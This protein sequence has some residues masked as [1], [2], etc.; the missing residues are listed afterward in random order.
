MVPNLSDGPDMIDELRCLW[1]IYDVEGRCSR[2]A[3]AP[4]RPSF[5]SYFWS[6]ASGLPDLGGRAHMWGGWWMCGISD[7]WARVTSSIREGLHFLLQHA[8]WCVDGAPG[9]I[10]DTGDATL[11]LTSWPFHK[12]NPKKTTSRCKL[13]RCSAQVE[14]TA[15]MRPVLQVDWTITD[16]SLT[17]WLVRLC[18]HHLAAWLASARLLT[19]FSPSPTLAARKC[20]HYL[21][22]GHDTICESIMRGELRLRVPWLSDGAE[23][24]IAVFAEQIRRLKWTLFGSGRLQAWEGSW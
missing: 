14:L 12:K 3:L 7:G 20:L 22:Q 4:L 1:P 13:T 8:E 9:V 24:N 2:A 23:V 21:W 5:M 17:S 6:Q 16:D 19:H 18:A 11:H 15:V 10:Y